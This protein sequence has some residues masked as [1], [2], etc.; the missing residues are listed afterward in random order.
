MLISA[1]HRSLKSI[2]ILFTCFI[3]SNP[4]VKSVRFKSEMSHSNSCCDMTIFPQLIFL[5][6]LRLV[7]LDRLSTFIFPTSFFQLNALLL[8]LSDIITLQ[9]TYCAKDSQHCFSGRSICVNGLLLRY[10]IYAFINH[11]VC[12]VE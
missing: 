5:L 6:K 8:S 12:E 1:G 10:I 7:N 9:L 4:P 11:L 2:S 3:L